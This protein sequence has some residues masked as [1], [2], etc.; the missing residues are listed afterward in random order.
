MFAGISGSLEASDIRRRATRTRRQ[1]ARLRTPDNEVQPQAQTSASI[2]SLRAT[3][4]T[5]SFRLSSSSDKQR[6]EETPP[7]LSIP[8]WKYEERRSDKD[9]PTKSFETLDIHEME[10]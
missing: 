6:D 9:I 10:A 8:P 2:P 4:S 1:I 3:L 7:T 5:V